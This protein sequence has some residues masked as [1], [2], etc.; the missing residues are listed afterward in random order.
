MKFQE[1]KERLTVKNIL[2]LLLGM[3]LINFGIAYS[4]QASLGTSPVSSLPYVFSQFTPLTVGNW[5]VIVH[6]TALLLQILILRKDFNPINLGQLLLA[7]IFGFITD[8][9]IM[10]V[11]TVNCPTYLHQ[12]L[13]CILGTVLIG[14]GV[15]FE[16]E[17]NVMMVALEGLGYTIA[18]K[19][20]KKFGNVKSCQDV[21]IVALAIIISLVAMH[22]VVG[23][24][25]G[26]VFA[27]VAVGQ[28][29][30]FTKKIVFKK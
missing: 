20:N 17:A 6:S 10:V 4:I 14:V 22:K 30:K 2:M 28:I 27:A 23:V 25:E 9:A 8:F 16:V 3:V 12:W 5:T 18:T 26:T 19:Y 21:I 29:A 13:Y 24:R 1:F 15:T 11:G 7:V